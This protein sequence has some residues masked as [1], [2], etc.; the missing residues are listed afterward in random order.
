MIDTLWILS[1]KHLPR[2]ARRILGTVHPY[3]SGIIALSLANDYPNNNFN[4]LTFDNITT[5][6]L[7]YNTVAFG[8]SLTAI[9][10]CLSTSS[11]KFINFVSTG[12]AF[13][14]SLF[15]FCWNALIHFICIIVI[16]LSIL[17]I[18]LDRKLITENSGGDFAFAFLIHMATNIR[19]ISVSRKFPCYL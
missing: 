6:F 17:Y 5:I 8:F 19:H 11:Q 12:P 7:T 13:R 3:L 18:G 14:D 10:I 15:V 16:I 9:A 1:K 2:N 4:T